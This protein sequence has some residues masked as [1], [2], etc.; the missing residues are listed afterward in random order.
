MTVVLDRLLSDSIFRGRGDTARVG[1]AG[2]SLGGY[3]VVALAGGRT[4][5]RQFDAFCASAKRDFTCESQ[6]ELPGGAAAVE[7][8]ASDPAVVASFARAGES[9]R[10]RRIGAVAALAPAVGQAFTPASLRAV[11]IPM[12]VFGGEADT[13]A[14]P[15]TNAATIAREV[16]GAR[17][18]LLPSVR[19]YTFLSMCTPLGI[20]ASPDLCGDEPGVSRDEVHENVS[21]EVGDFFDKALR[22]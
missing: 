22:K 21:R 8:V 10:D 12:L 1:A 14:P 17:F 4:D 11:D 5:L 7:S 3:T 2:F 20:R 19:H 16:S 18:V 15:P 6:P 13:V 9:Y